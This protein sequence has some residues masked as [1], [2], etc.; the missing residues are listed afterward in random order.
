MHTQRDRKRI[1][2]RK[3]GNNHTKETEMKNRDEWMFIT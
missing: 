3:E 1:R 2:E